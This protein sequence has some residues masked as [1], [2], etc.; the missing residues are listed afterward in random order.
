[1]ELFSGLVFISSMS[2]SDRIQWLFDASDFSGSGRLDTDEII[3]SI[4]GILNGFAQ[5]FNKKPK[6][7]REILSYH[8]NASS[9]G[10][11]GYIN[12]YIY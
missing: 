6:E 9:T 3:I 5:V 7:E 10:K 1:M 11:C 12:I 4:K 8:Q 2:L